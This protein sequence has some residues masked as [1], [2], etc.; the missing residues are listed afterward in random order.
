[1]AIWEYNLKLIF[2]CVVALS[3]IK[4]KITMPKLTWKGW[5]LGV[6]STAVMAA[7]AYPL[8][9]RL[10]LLA[11]RLRQEGGEAAVGE[12]FPMSTIE[13]VSSLCAVSL[14]SVVVLCITAALWVLGTYGFY[15]L[16]YK[17]QEK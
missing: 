3:I 8:G 5:T 14:L 2:A 1:M 12:M 11:W 15:F 10:L 17:I 16:K 7:F 13:I 4:L 9:F 6:L